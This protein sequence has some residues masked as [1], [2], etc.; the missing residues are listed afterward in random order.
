MLSPQYNFRCFA[1]AA[2]YSEQCTVN[3]V[4]STLQLCT[5]L[6]NFDAVQCMSDA[7]MNN[8][9]FAQ[10]KRFLSI[11]PC[12]SVHYARIHNYLLSLTSSL[13]PSLPPSL[14]ACLPPSLL[15]SLP[16]SLLPSFPPSFPPSLPPSSCPGPHC[17]GVR[18]SGLSPSL[19]PL[20]GPRRP[21]GGPVAGGVLRGRRRASPRYVSSTSRERPATSLR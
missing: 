3:C 20:R 13:P 4:Q 12:F 7:V 1:C 9:F 11:Q 14:P 15:P 17:S 2:V 18:V 10:K 5:E 19:P 21:P 16:P 8:L 6:S